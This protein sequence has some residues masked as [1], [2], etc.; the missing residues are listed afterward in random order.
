M[1]T[2]SSVVGIW[3]F[4]NVSQNSVDVEFKNPYRW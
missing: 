3:V 4:A 1:L 2:V